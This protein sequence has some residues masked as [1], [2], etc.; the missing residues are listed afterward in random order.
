MPS[1]RSLRG[2]HAVAAVGPD[3]SEAHSWVLAI[4]A[5]SAALGQSPDCDPSGVLDGKAVGLA[6]RH[7]RSAKRRPKAAG[8]LPTIID[9]HYHLDPKLKPLDELPAEM[10]ASG[11]DRVALMGKQIEPMPDQSRLVVATMQFCQASA[12]R[13]R[14]IAA[15]SVV[16]LLFS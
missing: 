15:S 2:P 4:L 7:H 12:W 5:E 14:S 3:E 9:C 10:D 6:M 1:A 13:R 11:V 8:S 16:R